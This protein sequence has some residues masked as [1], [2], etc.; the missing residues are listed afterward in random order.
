VIMQTEDG[1]E[2][3]DGQLMKI[4]VDDKVSDEERR[5]L[6]G[7]G[8]DIFVVEGLNLRWRSKDLHL[9]VDVDGR[10][11]THVGLLQH[12][13]SVDG[14]PVKVGGVGAVVTALASHG[15]G[16]ASHAMRYVKTLM[17]EE[18]GVDFGLLFC[19]DQLVSF[20]ERLGW[21]LLKVP[22]EIEQPSGTTTFPLNVMVLPCRAE[23]WPEGRVNLNGLP[24]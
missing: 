10:P 13:I 15:K 14:R 11:V 19:R 12:T 4:R 2:V 16:Y 8:E 22:V 20:Y 3:S 21:Q 17:C 23:A 9:F 18:W 7:W 5:E 24:W 1:K 6:F